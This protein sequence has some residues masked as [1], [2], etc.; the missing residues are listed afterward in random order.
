MDVLIFNGPASP[1]SEAVIEAVLKPT[2][3][4]LRMP[5]INWK[6]GNKVDEIALDWANKLNTKG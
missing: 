2:T 6:E 3:T 4:I 5:D 1:H